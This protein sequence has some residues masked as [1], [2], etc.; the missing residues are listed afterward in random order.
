MNKRFE[1]QLESL[2]NLEGVTVNLEV[3][4]HSGEKAKDVFCR[5]WPATQAG[6]TAAS[7]MV[8]NPFIKVFVIIFLELGKALSDRIC[9]PP[10]QEDQA[11]K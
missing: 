2:S 3:E 10:G 7:S 4:H 11:K 8:A 5:S 1:K 6:L 9:I